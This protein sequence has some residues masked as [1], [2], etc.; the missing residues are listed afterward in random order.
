MGNK[1][2][3]PSAQPEPLEKSVVGDGKLTAKNDLPISQVMIDYSNLPDQKLIYEDGEEEKE[4]VYI[5]RADD[6]PNEVFFANDESSI[7]KF[8]E[9]EERKEREAYIAK[10]L[11]QADVEA[12][13]KV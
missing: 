3:R 1:R 13:E 8:R 10:I 5:K 12:A 2:N 11:R 6:A 9:N 7:Q 4:E